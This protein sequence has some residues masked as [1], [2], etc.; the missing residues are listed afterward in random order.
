MTLDNNTAED[1]LEPKNFFDLPA[2][3]RN[4]IYELALEEQEVIVFPKAPKSNKTSRVKVPGILMAS[5][6][7]HGEILQIF[8]NKTSFCF[9]NPQRAQTWLR[10]LGAA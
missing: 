2:E 6:Q 3:I 7:I 1:Q 9:D 10:K 5:K 8:Y 4:E